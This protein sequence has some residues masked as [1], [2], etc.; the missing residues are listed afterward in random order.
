MVWLDRGQNNSLLITASHKN[1]L[2]FEIDKSWAI[3]RDVRT[4]QC[5]LIILSRS[6]LSARIV[7]VNIGVQEKIGLWTIVF[8]GIQA[9]INFDSQVIEKVEVFAVDFL[10][11]HSNWVSQKKRAAIYMFGEKNGFPSHSQSS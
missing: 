10:D 5:K 8:K 7:V 3:S 2:V 9:S 1:D 11:I 6:Q 4:W